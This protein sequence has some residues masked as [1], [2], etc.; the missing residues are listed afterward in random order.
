MTIGDRSQLPVDLAQAMKT[1]GLSHLTAVSGMNCGVV[2]FGT[3]LAARFLR[4][5]RYFASAFGGA[6]L[7][8]FIAVVGP[9]PSVIRASLM[10]SLGLL[11]MLGGRPKQLISLLCFTVIL[12][13]LFD[14]SLALSFGFAL[15]VAATAGLI[16]LG[17]GLQSKLA[18]ILPHWLATGLAIPLA[19]QLSCAPIIVLL[20]PALTIYALPANLLVAPVVACTTI[21]GTLALPVLPL[22]PGVAMVLL[23]LS[24][25]CVAWVALIAR[26][27]A[28]LPGAMLPWPDGPWGVSLMCLLSAGSFTLV[29]L[30]AERR[31]YLALVRQKCRV[32]LPDARL[33]RTLLNTGL[34][35]GLA[36]ISWAL[37]QL[38]LRLVY[39]L[40]P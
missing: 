37:S 30:L 13:L 32:Q 6:F 16:V 17:P 2:L 19:A 4:I 15:S 8:L 5:Q 1:T 40:P 23:T 21:L 20:N 39:A 26:F 3:I 25:L 18:R 9:D 31:K 14:S 10:G 38:L 36:V 7:V 22:L 12:V 29:F 11:S 24:G 35:L 33:R 27:F 34:G 28:V